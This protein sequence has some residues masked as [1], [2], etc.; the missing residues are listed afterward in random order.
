MAEYV[1]VAQFRELGMEN[2]VVERASTFGSNQRKTKEESP[3]QAESVMPIHLARLTPERAISIL[4]ML[5]PA[6]IEFYRTPIS[7]AP[8]AL[9]RHSPS[10]PATSTVSAAASKGAQSK[11]PEKT[12]IYGSVSTTDIAANLKAILA[13]DDEGARVPLG[14]EDITFIEKTDDYDRVKHLGVFEI[15]IRVK[16]GSDVIRRTIKVSAQD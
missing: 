1:T 10:I 12:S 14:S 3:A 7:V 6:N 5:L 11:I 15:D 4:S 2:V 9:Q 13:E 8:P 16:G